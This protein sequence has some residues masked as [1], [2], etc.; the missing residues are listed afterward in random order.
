MWTYL[1]YYVTNSC[2]RF[3][4]ALQPLSKDPNRYNVFNSFVPFDKLQ[5][6]TNYPIFASIIKRFLSSR[7]TR[8]ETPLQS[9]Y[10]KLSR[11][12]ETCSILSINNEHFGGRISRT[13]RGNLVPI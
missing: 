11:G 3:V 13:N 2:P 4:S 7:G 8:K 1:P 12:K 6:E 10:N 5:N 9:T